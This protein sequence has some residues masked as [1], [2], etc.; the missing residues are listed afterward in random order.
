M[1]VSVHDAHEYPIYNARYRLIV[2]LLDA[3]GDPV[4]PSSP[5]TEISQDCGTFADATN[6]ATELATSSGIVYVDLIASEMDTKSTVVQ[7]KSTGAKT[8][9][10][11]L[12]PRR[13]PVIRTGT[14]QAGASSTITLDASASARD[15]FYRG[16][17]V[18]I[19]NNT[20]TNAQGQA[21]RIIS[22]VGSTKVATIEGTWG[23]NPSSSSTF[24][25]L[26]TPEATQVIAWAGDVITTALQTAAD[27]RTEMDANSTQLAKIGI[28][29]GVSLAA[30]IAAAKTQVNAI[31]TDT[32]DIQSRIPAALV[33]S[34]MDCTIDGTGMEA[35]AVSAVQSGLATAAALAT[36]AGYLD[37][38]I[39][40]IL[41]DTGTTLDGKLNSIISLLD[42]ARGEP[43]Q[44]AP[45]VNPDTVTKIDYLYKAFRN[46][47]TQTATEFSVYADDG[48]TVDHKATVSDDGTTYTRGELATGA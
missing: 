7:V 43:G 37:S 25:I 9:I 31:E 45:P 44:G 11:A 34:R 14:A 41:E 22:Y 42:D 4:S 38:E 1:T 35:G 18:N 30:D 29:A 3:D 39:A 28:P 47:I 5:D 10:A 2:P 19:T 48:A 16:C 23:T 33:N 26:A 40:A 21:R 8:T 36:V 27:V 6:E 20:P 17:F 12:Y 24:E 46:K 13:L 32:Q 15:D